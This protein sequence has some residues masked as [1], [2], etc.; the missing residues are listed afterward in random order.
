VPKKNTDPKPGPSRP[1]VETSRK[2]KN[3]KIV[4]VR[5]YVRKSAE[6]DLDRLAR[7]L[8]DTFRNRLPDD[9]ANKAGNDKVA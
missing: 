7:A 1:M 8:I 3:G 9:K 2:A 4:I 6:Y 5:S